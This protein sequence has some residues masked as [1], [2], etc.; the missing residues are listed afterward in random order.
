MNRTPRTFVTLALSTLL[1]TLMTGTA[2]AQVTGQ[3]IHER[4]ENQQARIAQGVRSGQLTRGETRNLERR[5]RSVNRQ[6]RAMRRADGGHLTAADKAAL[7][8]RQNNI[9]RSI[10]R[11]KHNARVQ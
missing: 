3:T 1:S 8:R 10:Y 2:F 6:E 5:E 11:D 9:S 7:T 4:K